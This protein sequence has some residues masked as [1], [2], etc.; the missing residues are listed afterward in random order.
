MHHSSMSNF[1]TNIAAVSHKPSQVSRTTWGRCGQILAM[2]MIF[3]LLG[4]CAT[5]RS[6]DPESTTH[7]DASYDFSD[8]KEIVDSL[9]Q[10]LLGSPSIPTETVKPIIVIYGIDNETS[11]HISTSGITDDIRLSLIKSGEYRFINRKQRANLQEEADYQYAGFVPPEQR[12]TEGR[13]LGADFILSGTLRS[14]EKKQPKQIR[15]SK[16]KLVY[17]SMNLEL[18]NLE[19]GEI[20]WADN[21]EIARESSRPIIGW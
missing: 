17:Y 19:T 3:S 1:T 20:S 11:E 2:G 16:R 7:Y 8:K 5:T 12:V 9:T 15:L 21:V 14:I 4:A 18:T 6:I 13:Q 10:S